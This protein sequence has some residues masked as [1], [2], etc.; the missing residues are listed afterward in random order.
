[1]DIEYKVYIINKAK[2]VLGEI[3]HLAKNLRIKK[4]LNLGDTIEFTMDYNQFQQHI[5]A[6][7]NP[8]AWLVR[9]ATDIVV[10]RNGRPFAASR[11]A[12]WTPKFTA[13]ATTLDIRGEPLINF[14]ADQYISTAFT[15]DTAQGEIVW[16]VINACNLKPNG[17]YGIR[18]GAN[19]ASFP[20]QRNEVDK[21]VKDFITRLTRVRNGLDFEITVSDEIM[22]GAYTKYLQT[23]DMMGT[24]HRNELWLYPQDQ[25]I[26]DFSVDVGDEIYN[27]IIGIGSGNGEAAIRTLQEDTDSQSMYYRRERIVTYNSIVNMQPLIEN[28]QGV[29]DATKAEIELPKFT[30]LHGRLDLE[31]IHVGDSIHARVIENNLFDVDGVYRIIEMNISVSD[32]DVETPSITFDDYGIDDILEGQEES[33]D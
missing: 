16:A 25:G 30:F 8:R 13:N 18:K 21:Q 22:G 20:R 27:V 12:T 17:D 14:Y 5:G 2:V 3:R 19:V 33:D 10:F 32:E 23:Y 28:S 4:S 24:Y 1:M 29:L 26:K 6:D 31:R 7:G 15:S 9:G 11:L